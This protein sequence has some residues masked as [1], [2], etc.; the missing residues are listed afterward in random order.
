V[1][2][3]RGTCG[4]AA[5]V[6]ICAGP[7]TV[8]QCRGSPRSGMDSRF[9]CC[10]RQAGPLGGV[11]VPHRA[12][13][14]SATRRVLGYPALAEN[15]PLMAHM[16]QVAPP[17]TFFR[18]VPRQA[19][20][21]TSSPPTRPSARAALIDDLGL[22]VALGLQ[23]QDHGGLAGLRRPRST[24]CL[25]DARRRF[26]PRRLRRPPRRSPRPTQDRLLTW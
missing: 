8:R 9:R 5:S 2:P 24:R 15:A 25:S 14:G 22:I 4:T 20:C 10:G 11:A 17:Q 6:V 18:F 21:T 19:P 3:R 23:V 16:Q 12:V 13:A 1:R 7:G 26:A